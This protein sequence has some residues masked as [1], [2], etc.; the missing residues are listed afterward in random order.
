[1]AQLKRRL[2]SYDIET[3]NPLWWPTRKQL[4]FFYFDEVKE[5]DNTSLKIEL[6][7]KQLS[8]IDIEIKEKFRKFEEALDSLNEDKGEE[9]HKVEYPSLREV[10]NLCIASNG[11]WIDSHKVSRFICNMPPAYIK[12]CL[13]Y[14]QA[15]SDEVEKARV[16][17]FN[18]RQEFLRELKNRR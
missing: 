5:M 6:L 3:M 14:L 7:K 8:A 18:K 11:I 2:F 12:A 17:L 13:D 9:R 4:E 15:A 10:K 16:R 1:M